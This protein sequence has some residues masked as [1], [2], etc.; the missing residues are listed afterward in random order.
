MSEYVIYIIISFVCIVVCVASICDEGYIIIERDYYA[1]EVDENVLDVIIDIDG[2]SDDD[3]GF[4]HDDKGFS[5]DDRGF[6]DDDRGFSD[7]DRGF[8][9]IQCNPN[10]TTIYTT[11]PLN[12]P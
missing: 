7:D 1:N 12:P 3:R 6:S 8:S 2:F 9:E 10:P 5:H 11:I 4:S